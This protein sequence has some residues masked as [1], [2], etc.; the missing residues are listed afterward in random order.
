MSGLRG[1]T[2]SKAASSSIH[3]SLGAKSIESNLS[4]LT[5]SFLDGGSSS[6]SSGTKEPKP[7]KPKKE[8]KPEKA[9]PD[10]EEAV[11]EEAKPAKSESLRWC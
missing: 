10:K 2:W 4:L 9:K 6:S 11:A 7:Q 1:K 5:K 8:K 3:F